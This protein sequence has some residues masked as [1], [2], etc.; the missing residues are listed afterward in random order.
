VGCD[1]ATQLD[2]VPKTGT[3]INRYFAKSA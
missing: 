2:Q 3:L 1:A